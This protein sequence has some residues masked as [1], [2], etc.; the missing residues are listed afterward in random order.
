MSKKSKTNVVD[1][2][3]AVASGAAYNFAME[4]AAKKVPAVAEN[5]LIIKSLVAGLVGSGAV[6][7]S[8]DATYKAAGYGLLGVSGA[9]AASKVATM[10]SSGSMN[11][12]RSRVLNGINNVLNAKKGI[13]RN[14]MPQ[15]G[16]GMPPKAPVRPNNCAQPNY[17]NMAFSDAIYAM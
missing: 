4:A 10:L 1:I 2:V 12:N 7:F 5:Y 14:T 13:K 8:K 11:G 6:Y 16:L 17:A 9:S 15:M 3:A